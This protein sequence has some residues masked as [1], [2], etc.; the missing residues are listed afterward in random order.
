M[1]GRVANWR[2]FGK[3]KKWLHNNLSGW[4]NSAAEVSGYPVLPKMTEKGPNFFRV[5]LFT[6]KPSLFEEDL[7]ASNP[8]IYSTFS[9]FFTAGVFVKDNSISL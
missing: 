1:W 3:Q 4:K 8:L 2:N 6:N 5:F 9:E 7:P